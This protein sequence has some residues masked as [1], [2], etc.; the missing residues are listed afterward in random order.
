MQWFQMEKLYDPK[1]FQRELYLIDISQVKLAEVL[2][3]S[4]KGISRLINGQWKQ[5]ARWRR[6]MIEFTART[7]VAKS[8]A[9][10]WPVH[11]GLTLATRALQKIEFEWEVVHEEAVRY[12][13]HW[14]E[15]AEKSSQWLEQHPH[16]SCLLTPIVKTKG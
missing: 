4:E 1:K 15:D 14:I 16:P 2:K 10:G 9:L 11:V 6:A 3:Y 12:Q 13:K 8:F 5:A 7:I